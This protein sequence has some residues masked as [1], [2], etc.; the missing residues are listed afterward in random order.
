M[1]NDLIFSDPKESYT[2][3]QVSS[4]SYEEFVNQ[5]LKLCQPVII[6]DATDQW[7]AHEA[8]SFSFFRDK[9]T[10]QRIKIDGRAYKFSEFIDLVLKKDGKSP[11]LRETNIP[12]FFPELMEYLQPDISYTLPNRLKNKLLP[13]VLERSWGMRKGMVELLIGGE[14]S[15]FPFLHYDLFKSHGFVTQICGDKEFYLYSPSDSEYLYPK[16]TQRDVSSIQNI[17]NPDLQEFP[18]FAE[19][20]QIKVLVREG[21]SIFIP[22]GWWH[23]TKVITPSIAVLVNFMNDDK[24]TSFI[25]ESYWYYHSHKPFKREALRIYLY[26]IGILMSFYEWFRKRLF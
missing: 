15:G 2:I 12:I 10:T 23:T 5:Y 6:K 7:Q 21:E 1:L 14:G 11:Y 19:A 3:Q 18:L 24:W 9:Y 8:W 26:L 20:K 22:S 17:E 25:H 16:S 13:K 4:L